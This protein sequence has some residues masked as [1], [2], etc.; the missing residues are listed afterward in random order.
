LVPAVEQ[1][2]RRWS[3][4]IDI[5]AVFDVR[6]IGDDDVLPEI[7]THLYRIV[8]EALN[9][10]AKHAAARCAS[11]RL[12]RRGGNIVLVVKDDGRGFDLERTR[13]E[14]SSLGLI[15]MRERAQLIG[16]R[17]RIQTAP[18]QGTSIRVYLPFPPREGETG[19]PNGDKGR[20]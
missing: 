11:V 20:T 13:T 15:G 1:F 3:V 5:P 6:K 16:G 7:A 4:A 14:T 19:R 10:V 18:N 8:Q 9:N 2:V 12:E 17:L